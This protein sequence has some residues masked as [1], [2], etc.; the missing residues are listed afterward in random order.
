MATYLLFGSYT[1]ESMKAVTASRTDEAIALIKRYG[2]E[3]K[4]GYALLGAVDLVVVLDLPDTEHAMQT[5]AALTRLLGVSFRTA[6]AVSIEAF[7]KLMA[8]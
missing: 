1:P 3:F 5:S 7:D 4:A 8:G 6:P 2:G